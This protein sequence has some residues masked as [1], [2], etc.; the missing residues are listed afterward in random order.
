MN[1]IKD[2][3]NKALARHDDKGMQQDISRLLF[4]RILEKNRRRNARLKLYFQAAIC[5]V[6]SLL[7]MFMYLFSFIPMVP[8][9]VLSILLLAICVLLL[10]IG[11]QLLLIFARRRGRVAS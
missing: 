1:A 10:D 7:L 4:E 5:F 9:Q 11:Q 8:Q 6:M 2:A 3:L